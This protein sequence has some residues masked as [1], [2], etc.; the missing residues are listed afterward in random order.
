MKSSKGILLSLSCALLILAPASPHASCCKNPPSSK[1]CES[2]ASADVPIADDVVV[3]VGT[4]GAVLAEELTADRV[5]SVIA[6]HNGEDLARDS[7][8]KLSKNVPTT[9]LA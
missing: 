5:T 2:S 1:P 4:A 9:V 7:D 8:I 6:L 3:G